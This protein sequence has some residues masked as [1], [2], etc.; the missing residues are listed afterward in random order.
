[1]LTA[2]PARV[3]SRSSQSEVKFWFCISGPETAAARAEEHG[4][5]EPSVHVAT[6][7]KKPG[8]CFRWMIFQKE[9]FE[10]SKDGFSLLVPE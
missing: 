1:M 9:I 3:A 7:E 6:A 8:G 2:L 10:I 5:A 4:D